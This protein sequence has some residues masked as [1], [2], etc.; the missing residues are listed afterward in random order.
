MRMILLQAAFLIFTLPALADG[1][2]EALFPT[3]LGSYKDSRSSREHVRC[4]ALKREEK[5]KLANLVF[6]GKF[7]DR[8]KDLKKKVFLD[9]YRVIKSWKGDAKEG[10]VFIVEVPPPS[11]FCT[12]LRSVIYFGAGV[13]NSGGFIVYAK[14]AP[15]FMDCC[16]SEVNDRALSSSE[17][18]GRINSI[19]EKL[20]NTVK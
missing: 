10:D 19:F 8:K 15:A 9:E 7:L 12:T 13:K 2:K 20:A 6:F 4:G 17:E 16:M 14:G 11:D 3:R 1:S 5:F 18:L